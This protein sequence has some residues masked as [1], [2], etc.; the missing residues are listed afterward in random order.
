VCLYGAVANTQAAAAARSKTTTIP[1]IMVG[2]RTPLAPAPWPDRG[3][4]AGR[5]TGLGGRVWSG[6]MVRQG[7]DTSK[8]SRSR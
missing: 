3:S 1:I 5:G 7:Q 2:A 8:G 6:T 4:P